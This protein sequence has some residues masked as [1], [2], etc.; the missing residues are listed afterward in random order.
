M[1]IF[2]H[3]IICRKEIGVCL[4]VYYITD[5]ESRDIRNTKYEGDNIYFN[6]D[7]KKPVYSTH[8]ITFWAGRT[9]AG[10]GNIDEVSLFRI[11]I[12]DRRLPMSCFTPKSAGGITTGNDLTGRIFMTFLA[13]HFPL[14][15]P[16]SCMGMSCFPVTS[17]EESRKWVLGDGRDTILP[18]AK[19]PIYVSTLGMI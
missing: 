2:L 11:E 6:V 3:K 17:A 5:S 10:S 1:I 16:S 12:P 9:V 8:P 14:H 7:W 15:S 18:L 4:Q 13:S 19:S